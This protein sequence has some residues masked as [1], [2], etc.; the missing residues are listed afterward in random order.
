MTEETKTEE[1]TEEVKTEAVKTEEKP[2]RPGYDPVDFEELNLTPEQREKVEPR[3]KYLY[4]NLK[5]GE[6]ERAELRKW[7][8]K[9][10]E[11]I[12]EQNARLAKLETSKVEDERTKIENEIVAAREEGRTREELQLQR[13]LADLDKKPEPKPEKKVEQ[14]FWK[15]PLES[16]AAEVDPQGNLRRPWLA[17]DHP[18]HEVANGK[19]LTLFNEWK[20]SG[21][22]VTQQ[23]LPMFLQQLD[24][25]MVRTNGKAAPTVLPTSQTKGPAS[26]D[27]ELT[28]E[29]KFFADRTMQHV[30]DQKERYRRYAAQK[31]RAK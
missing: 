12:D 5:A 18:D 15:E 23:T 21:L 22:Q 10:Q 7:N 31:S 26:K 6:K 30:P 1:K 27:P 20:A 17:L 3:I 28:T 13:R 4:G 8:D 2:R 19:T 9:L 14:E 29:E 24:S 25:R 11:S 16:W